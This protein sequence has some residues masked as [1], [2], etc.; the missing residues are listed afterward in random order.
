[1]S[2]VGADRDL[3]RAPNQTDVVI[4]GIRRVSSWAVSTAKREIAADDDLN[5][6]RIVAVDVDANIRA[7]KKLSRNPINTCSVDGKPE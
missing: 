6:L 1:M 7:R 2:E 4:G 5:L 3:V